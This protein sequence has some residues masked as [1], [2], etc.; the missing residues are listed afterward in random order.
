MKKINFLPLL[1]FV[2]I[3]CSV[4][5]EHLQ[6]LDSQISTLNGEYSANAEYPASELCGTNTTNYFENF[7][8]VQVTTED[9]SLVVTVTAMDGA[10]L[11]ATKLHIVNDP[12]EFP[13]VGQG[14]LPPGQM[15]HKRSFVPAVQSSTFKFS[16]EDYDA[17]NIYIATQS[18]FSD[19]GVVKETWAG[20]IAGNSGN[21]HYFE[22][23]LGSCEP[24]PCEG[25]AGG[26][27]TLT[28]TVDHYLARFG[29]DQSQARTLFRGYILERGVDRSGTF[30]PTPEELFHV[31]NATEGYLGTFNTTYTLTN[32]EGCSDS[33]ELSLVLIPSNTI[34][35]SL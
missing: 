17:G 21:W 11:I 7:G 14:N 8:S 35:S 15:K 22:Y 24:S 1:A 31:I 33:A 29:G 9:D 25:L 12:I 26:D 18:T 34:S 2:F 10:S 27:N 16:L 13:T 19:E 32:S 23:E 6:D 28:L 4:D 5:N 30:D 3:A 20:N